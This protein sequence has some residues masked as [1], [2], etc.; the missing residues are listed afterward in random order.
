MS[1][2]EIGFAA[3]DGERPTLVTPGLYDVG[4]VG[5]STFM[6]FGRA[7]KVHLKF[8]IMTMGEHFEKPISR[9][10]NV[11]RLIGRPGGG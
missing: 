4:Y 5:Y 7:P 10:C 1:A 2:Q 8:R 11:K 9:F 6:M 3:I